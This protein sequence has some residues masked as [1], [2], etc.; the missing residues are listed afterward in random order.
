MTLQDLTSDELSRLK[1]ILSDSVLRKLLESRVEDIKSDDFRLAVK[2]VDGMLKREYNRGMCQA[3]EVI[4]GLNA[5]VDEE[6]DMRK[7]EE[8]LARVPKT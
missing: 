3:Y 5:S 1:S 4:A 8:A 7:E 6:Y 2:D